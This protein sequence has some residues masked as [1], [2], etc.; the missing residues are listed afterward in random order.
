M[1]T[2]V[3]VSCCPS[4]GSGLSAGYVQLGQESKPQYWWENEITLARRDG[5]R[6]LYCRQQNCTELMWIHIGTLLSHSI[7]DCMRCGWAESARMTGL[8]IL[9][10]DD[11]GRGGTGVE[12]MEGSNNAC[13]KRGE[14]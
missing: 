12:G 8:H 9:V 13:D 7:S 4:Q 3:E 14:T 11:G 2:V 6:G 1:T 5:N 10:F